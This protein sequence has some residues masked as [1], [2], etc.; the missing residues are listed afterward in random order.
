MRGERLW[1][2]IVPV[3]EIYE[4]MIAVRKGPYLKL[5]ADGSSA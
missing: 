1:A 2:Y 4:R 3:T 5:R